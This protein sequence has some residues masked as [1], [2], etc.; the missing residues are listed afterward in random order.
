MPPPPHGQGFNL[1]KEFT[2]AL[3]HIDLFYWRGK[4]Q[5]IPATLP[6]LLASGALIV[7]CRK[8]FGF[9]P[10]LNSLLCEVA[11]FLFLA[12]SCSPALLR[13]RARIP[14]EIYLLA[15]LL[16]VCWLLAL[17][18]LSISVIES[19]R[20]FEHL[21]FETSWPTAAIYA[22]LSTAVIFVRSHYLGRKRP[23]TT[24]RIIV[25][26]FVWLVTTILLHT[27]IMD[28]ATDDLL[29]NMAEPLRALFLS[30]E[31]G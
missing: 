21:P 11:F 31:P 22:G 25:P 5:P 8:I 6:L 10:G 29:G 24:H 16:A 18:M 19:L 17:S 30:G 2:E 27:L 4:I 23:Q 13:P 7:P 20:W 15:H 12:V 14:S 9:D 28:T 1:L 3:A 26:V